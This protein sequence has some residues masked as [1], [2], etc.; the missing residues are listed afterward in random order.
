MD[1]IRPEISGIFGRRGV[2][3]RALRRP[4]NT[5][6]RALCIPGWRAG[7]PLG[8]SQSAGRVHSNIH[9]WL[10]SSAR[11]SSLG[12]GDWRHLS[13]S[14]MELVLAACDVYAGGRVSAAFEAPS[15]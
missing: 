2:D 9:L 13:V 14:G 1:A 6:G 3:H 4:E 5:T 7:G 11:D 12:C 15:G 10:C 8:T